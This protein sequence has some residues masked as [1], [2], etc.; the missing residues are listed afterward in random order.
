M[1]LTTLNPKTEITPHIDY[2]IDYA[3]RII[4]PIWTDEKCL[5]YFYYRGKKIKLHIP[6]DGYPWFLNVGFKHGVEHLGMKKRTVLMFS[7]K[8]IED[9]VHLAQN[10]LN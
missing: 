1:R 5:N 2:N 10:T 7:L 6:A 4:V 3:V 8:G 9:I